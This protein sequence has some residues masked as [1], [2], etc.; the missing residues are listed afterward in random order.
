MLAVTEYGNVA[1]WSTRAV[2]SDV[3]EQARLK[4]RELFGLTSATIFVVNMSIR[5]H[6][7]QS[8]GAIEDVVS[9]GR[10]NTITNNMRNYL[11]REEYYEGARIVY[12]QICTLMQKGRIPQPMKYLSNGCIALLAAL[13]LLLRVVIRY[14]STLRRPEV[15]RTAGE[16]R[17]TNYDRRK[18][19]RKRTYSPRQRDH[20]SGCGGSS[21][22]S[23]GGGGSSC[24]SCGSGGSSSF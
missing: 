13:M 23:C 17:I 11:T 15:I 7:I 18:T 9:T 3:V 20:D 14:S 19:G 1:F 24:S 5:K 16:L 4:R 10:A 12:E 6:T 22:S 8:Y 2:T 21:C